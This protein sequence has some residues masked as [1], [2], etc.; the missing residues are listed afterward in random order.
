MSTNEFEALFFNKAHNKTCFSCGRE[1]VSIH[2][3]QIYCRVWRNS[4][5]KF[6]TYYWSL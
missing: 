2:T 4:I 6:C 3:V 1:T 5:W